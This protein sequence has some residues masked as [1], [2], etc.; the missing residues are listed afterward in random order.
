MA[1]ENLTAG[2]YKGRVT[3]WGIKEV[4]IGEKKQLV[5]VVNFNFTAGAASHKM[6]WEG[7][8]FKKDGD[9]SKKTMDTLE[10]CGFTSPTLDALVENPNALNTQKELLVTVEMVNGYWKIEWV[11]DPDD[12]SAGSVESVKS[13]KGYNLSAINTALAAKAREKVAARPAGVK[14]HAPGASADPE[15]PAW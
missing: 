13:L 6:K 5:V 3:D 8:L 7:F 1:Y 11:N 15:E 2:Q 10:T 14:N 4:V 12:T 9:L